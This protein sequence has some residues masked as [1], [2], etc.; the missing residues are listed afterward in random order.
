MPRAWRGAKLLEELT[1]DHR[2]LSNRV[3]VAAVD[4]LASES[5]Y[6]AEI[7]EGDCGL[8]QYSLCSPFFVRLLFNHV[9]F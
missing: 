7:A 2:H 8:V 4:R 1:S 9:D 3:G 6:F 5:G